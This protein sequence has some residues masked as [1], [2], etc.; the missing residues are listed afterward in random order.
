MIQSFCRIVW[1]FPEKLKIELTHDPAIPLLGTYLEKTL[2][3]NDT[4]TPMF[5]AALLINTINRIWQQPKCPSTDEW[6]KMWYIDSMKYYSAIKK[7]EMPFA[8]TWMDFKR[9]PY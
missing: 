1:R 2:L 3:Q 8:A 7:N 4:C 5:I 6:I 9:L